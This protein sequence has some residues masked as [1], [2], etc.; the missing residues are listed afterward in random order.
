[1][2][3]H[4][5]STSVLSLGTLLEPQPVDLYSHPLSP[6]PDNPDNQSGE[7][8]ITTPT[9][10]THPHHNLHQIDPSW[11]A[12]RRPA[13]I[14]SES[15]IY[16]HHHHHDNGSTSSTKMRRSNSSASGTKPVLNSRNL[17]FDEWITSTAHPVL[18][19]HS[20]IPTEIVDDDKAVQNMLA[21]AMSEE[22]FV[23][24]PE[25]P[26]ETIV[27][28]LSPMSAIGIPVKIVGAET[29]RPRSS[30]SLSMR[31]WAGIFVGKGD[32]GKRQTTATA[33]RPKL[34]QK[35]SFSAPDTISTQENAVED[36]NPNKG[37]PL[38]SAFF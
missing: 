31:K 29:T 16:H 15:P 11:H 8:F 30:S 28:P 1:M 24:V 6:D 21:E 14:R 23:S 33:A 37:I 38:F 7:T 32:P 4:S 10:E 9:H 22:T 3:S 26:E 18:A 2:R 17:I 19:A 34:T 27:R 13:S 5:R 20:L 25:K 12:K 35:R 36:T